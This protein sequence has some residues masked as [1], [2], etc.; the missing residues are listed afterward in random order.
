[1]PIG[2][3]MREKTE[4]KREKDRVGER[5]R[6]SEREGEKEIERRKERQI[7]G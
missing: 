5:E 4:I 7:R 6:V 3:G 2:W 1:M